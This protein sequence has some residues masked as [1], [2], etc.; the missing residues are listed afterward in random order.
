[1]PGDFTDILIRGRVV[2]SE[3]LAE[4]RRLA[5][6]SGKKV[7][8]ELIRLGYATGDEV[9]RALAQEHGLGLRQSQGSGDSALGVGIGPRIGCPRELQSCRCRRKKVR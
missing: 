6:D 1:M 5:K 9:M 3:Q 7:A 4:A 8:D 2:S